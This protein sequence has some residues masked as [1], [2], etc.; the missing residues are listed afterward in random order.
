MPY[1]FIEGITLADVAFEATGKTIEDMFISAGQALTK[2]QVENPEI[3]EPKI[4]IKFTVENVD[5]E[6][7]LHD[8]LQELIF[9][10]DA[11]LLLFCEYKLKITKL[12]TG[13]W[14]LVATIKGEEINQKK[15]ELLVDAKAVSWHMFEVKKEKDWRCFIIIDV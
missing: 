2:I 11:K 8:F 15:H 3:I 1:K 12:K 7:L 10:K 13:N 9:Y 6:R 5:E 4:A 14:K